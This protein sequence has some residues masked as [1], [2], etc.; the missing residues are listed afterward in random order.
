MGLRRDKG[1]GNQA[2][3]YQAEGPPVPTLVW[4]EAWSHIFQMKMI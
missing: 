4:T 2:E 1:L 3:F